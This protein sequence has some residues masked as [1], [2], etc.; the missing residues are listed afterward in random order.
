MIDYKKRF[1]VLDENGEVLNTIVASEEFMKSNFEYY[2]L[3]PFTE[4]TIQFFKVNEEKAW[5]DQQLKDTDWVVPL[6]DYPQHAAY[7]TYRQALRD[8][9]QDPNFP[10]QEFRPK[11]N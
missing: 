2:E 11:L 10:N 3:Y 1:N 4:D 9:P 5:R 8:W 7:L 6:T